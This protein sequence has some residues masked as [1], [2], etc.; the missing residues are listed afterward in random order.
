MT[1]CVKFYKDQEFIQKTE[2]GEIDCGN[3]INTIYELSAAAQSHKGYNILMDVRDTESRLSS[4]GDILEL[5]SQFAKHKTAFQNKIAMLI[6]Y[7]QERAEKA[8]KFKICMVLNDFKF[9]YF[10]DYDAAMDWLS[11]KS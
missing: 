7:I 8:E 9:D 4:M 6:P 10:T 1:I 3:A 2:A 11:K 5:S